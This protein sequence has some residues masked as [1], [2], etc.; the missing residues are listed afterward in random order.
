M[1]IKSKK[2]N[3]GKGRE[4]RLKFDVVCGEDRYTFT[5]SYSYQKLT[6]TQVAS[7]LCDAL[8]GTTKVE[9]AQG[10]INFTFTSEMSG[11]NIGFLN[12]VDTDLY[13]DSSSTEKLAAMDELRE[14]L[15]RIEPRAI[16]K[17]KN[18]EERQ[19]DIVN[20]FGE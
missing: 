17:S 2:K 3:N 16:S 13:E 15:C 1:S 8:M 19:A 11:Q 4:E 6:N 7:I 5:P 10:N 9:D 12:G 14:V 20:E 18:A